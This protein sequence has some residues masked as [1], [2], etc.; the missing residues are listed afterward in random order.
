MSKS[1]DLCS[2]IAG[3]ATL[4]RRKGPTAHRITICAQQLTDT[5]GF[6]GFTMEDLAESA[7]VSRRTLFNYF[8][9]KLDAVLGNAPV[10]EPELL[11]QFTA[12]GP[13]GT[14]LDDLCTVLVRIVSTKGFT[15]AQAE[16]ARRIIRGNPRLLSAAHERFEAVAEEFA[17]LII[18]REGEGFGTARARLLVTVLACLYDVAL[19]DV[20]ADESGDLELGDAYL[21]SLQT[22]RGL[23]V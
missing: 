9:G 18:Q 3:A 15:R 11:E 2:R 1:A 10:I 5:H 20:L 4:K 17:D 13:S 23:L 8:P 7:G 19:K 12:G 14:L 21:H 16:V 6:D 22:L